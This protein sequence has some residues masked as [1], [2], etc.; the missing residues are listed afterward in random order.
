MNN[1]NNGRTIALISLIVCVLGLAIGFAAYSGTVEIAHYPGLGPD[2]DSFMVEFSP[3][4]GKPTSNI[5]DEIYTIKPKVSSDKVK[6][7]AIIAKNSKISGFY[8]EF[9]SPGQSVE[10]KFYAYNSG[11]YDAFL[12]GIAFTNV[13]GYYS[14]KKCVSFNNDSTVQKACEGISISIKVGQEAKV[15]SSMANISNHLLPKKEAEEIIVTISYEKGST[16][17]HSP[18]RVYFGDIYLAYSTVD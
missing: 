3:I 9:N 16:V 14:P 10:Y 17:A 6:A 13:F 11:K 2:K 5:P 4:A 1:K 15:K 18:F 12:N 8:A 7:N